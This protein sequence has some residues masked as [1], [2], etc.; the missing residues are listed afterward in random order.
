M[1][2]RKPASPSSTSAPGLDGVS[3]AGCAAP[4]SNRMD[5]VP[6][7]DSGSLDAALAA[8]SVTSDALPAQS[9]NDGKPQLLG[10]NTNGTESAFT[11][12]A[13]AT[14]ASASTSASVSPPETASA[15]A[16][17]TGP[18]HAQLDETLSDAL[19]GPRDRVFLLKQERDM[20]AFVKDARYVYGPY[21][22]AVQF[23]LLGGSTA[24]C[25]CCSKVPTLGVWVTL[26]G[27]RR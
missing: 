23:C 20:I 11:P 7:I 21:V 18:S 19:K 2:L 4:S 14:S 17:T 13:M 3:G 16:S 5:V 8:L 10:S 6:G 22:C 26:S 24:V 12:P 1:L 9:S 27:G 15:P 25:S